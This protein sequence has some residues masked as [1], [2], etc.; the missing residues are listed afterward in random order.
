MIVIVTGLMRTGTSLVSRQLHRIGVPMGTAM[1]F[2]QAQPN[3]QEDWEDI[4][5]TDFMLN[6]IIGH[7][8]DDDVLEFMEYYIEKRNAINGYLWGVKSPFALPYVQL[9]RAAS[10]RVKVIRTT[11]DTD[12]TIASLAEQTDLADVLEIQNILMESR[13][14]VPNMQIDLSESLDRPEY[15]KRKL[16]DL[17]RSS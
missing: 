8:S 15:V 6:A 12:D 10:D 7:N 3:G 17:T 1:R 16:L 5:F 9:I 2:P 4:E 13:P 14:F 11:R